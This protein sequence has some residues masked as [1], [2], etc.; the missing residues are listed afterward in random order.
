MKIS[1]KFKLRSIVGQNVII[2]QGKYGGDMTKIIS[3]NDSSV[4]L[5]NKFHEAEFTID[6][7]TAALV[8]E[9]EI[10]ENLA[11]KDAQAWCDKI[12]ECGLLEK[13]ED[14]PLLSNGKNE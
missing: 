12:A 4:F 7:V 13:E 14:E 2:M 9:Y 8:E 6:D 3:L 11:R 5:W 10:D 1:P